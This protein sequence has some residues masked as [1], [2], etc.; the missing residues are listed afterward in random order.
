MRIFTFLIFLSTSI[1]ST[2]TIAQQVYFPDQLIIKFNET[3]TVDSFKA[4]SSIASLLSEHKVSD[5]IPLIDVDIYN[6]RTKV[7]THN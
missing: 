4:K 2:H 6:G 7:G 3:G 1:L 5:F